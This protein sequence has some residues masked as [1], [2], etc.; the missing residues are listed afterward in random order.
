[1]LKNPTSAIG[2][3]YT[4]LSIS[5]L[6]TFKCFVGSC[7][8]IYNYV[9]RRILR[10]SHALFQLVPQEPSNSISAKM[11][12]IFGAMNIGEKGNL[13]HTPMTI[14]SAFVNPPTNR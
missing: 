9:Y 7:F 2:K 12:T 10:Q 14:I 5:R 11:K 13:R 1:M 6:F 4:S 8:L 3:F